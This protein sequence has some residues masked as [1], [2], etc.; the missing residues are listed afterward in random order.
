M[1][2]ENQALINVEEDEFVCVS[3]DEREFDTE[4]ALLQHCQNARCHKS[5]SCKRCRWLFISTKAC[6]Q[7]IQD[8]QNHWICSECSVD[9]PEELDLRVH[10]ET[11]HSI[12]YDCQS[13]LANLGKHRVEQ[14]NRCSI[15][16]QEFENENEVLMLSQR[17]V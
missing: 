12:C 13:R 16:D 2:R 14:H 10:M 6:E 11:S 1:T 9:Q 7:H 17:G 5:E 3:C 15:C 8:S 4:E